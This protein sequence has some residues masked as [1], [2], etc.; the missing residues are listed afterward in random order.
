M[1]DGAPTTPEEAPEMVA[2]PLLA[3]S[4]IPTGVHDHL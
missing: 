1:A 2:P 3:D 4:G